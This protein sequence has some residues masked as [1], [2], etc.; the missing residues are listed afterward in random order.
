MAFNPKS[1]KDALANTARAGLKKISDSESAQKIAVAAAAMASQQN[2]QTQNINETN[3]YKIDQRSNPSSNT[4]P[5]FTT[6]L[7]VSIAMIV[8]DWVDF[9]ADAGTGLW[10]NVVE[11]F[12]N[13][14]VQLW[15]NKKLGSYN[16]KILNIMQWAEMV[17]VIDVL[18]LY[19]IS[20]IGLLVYYPFAKKNNAKPKN[21][22]INI[23]NDI[24]S[25]EKKEKFIFKLKNPQQHPK[26]FITL[27]VL[28]AFIFAGLALILTPQGASMVNNI[29]EDI[30]FYLSSGQ[31]TNQISQTT[32]IITNAPAKAWAAATAKWNDQIDI[33]T[34][35]KKFVDYKG[36]VDNSIN[37]GLTLDFSKSQSNQFISGTIYQIFGNLK[38]RS[39]DSTL[40]N[41]F[42]IECNTPANTNINL[43][44]V[45]KQGERGVINQGQSIVPFSTLIGQTLPVNCDLTPA[46]ETKITTNSNDFR[47]VALRGTF[48]F[49]TSAYQEIDFVLDSALELAKKQNFRQQTYTPTSTSGFIQIKFGEFPSNRI[50]TTGT[51][52]NFNGFIQLKVV[53]DVIVDKLGDIYIKTPPNL[54]VV[55]CIPGGSEFGQDTYLI[56][57]TNLARFENLK[58]GD[59]IAINC[60]FR[61]DTTVLDAA[62]TWTH[63][64]FA[65]LVKDYQVSVEDTKKF[66]F[67]PSEFLT[68]T[69]YTQAGLQCESYCDA[70]AGCRCDLEQCPTGIIKKDTNCYGVDKPKETTT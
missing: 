6:V 8:Y 64:A 68:I 11:I 51:P 61:A 25:S 3:N 35:N 38:G 22:S 69:S 30:S 54:K 53:E 43:L 12:I 1:F 56:P 52:D 14:P 70:E 7:I 45:T 33:A 44:C 2:S 49:T 20:A 46:L 29:R 10:A 16:P 34:G 62:S 55:S 32:A 19:T 47:N 23:N 66:E 42:D 67:K 65:V 26:F 40:C 63:E 58:Q 4:F 27:I 15:M 21:G 57:A 13:Y 60:W 31:L 5:S 50:L 18:P 39:P 37:L 36:K 17:P 24:K 41:Y 28:A 48:P 59:E 9:T